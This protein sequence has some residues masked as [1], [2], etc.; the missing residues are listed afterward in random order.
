[1]KRKSIFPAAVILLVCFYC[2]GLWAAPTTGRQAETA[3][4]GW[5]Q[6]NPNPLGANLGNQ[7]THAETF[8]D[9]NNQ[10]LYHIVYL[11]PEGF[12][13]VSADDKVEPIIG[14]VRD[15]MYDP[16]D[17]NPLA[18]LLNAD[19]RGRIAAARGAQG[20]ADATEFQNKWSGLTTAGENLNE[21][22][23]GDDIA[24]TFGIATIDEPRIDPLL[25]T[26]W[27]Q[28]DVA[29]KC[30]N[31]Y[32]PNQYPCGCVATAMAQLMYYYQH[33]TGGIGVHGFSIKINTT[34]ETWYTRGGDGIGGAYD[35]S[36]MVLDPDL[37]TTDTERKAMGALCYDA[38]LSVNMQYTSSESTANTLDAADAF[39][40]TFDYENAIKGYNSGSNIGAGLNG[41]IN[42]NLDGREAVI[43][44]ITGD[45]GHAIVCD[46]YGYNSSTMYHHLNLGWKE[47]AND[48]WYNLPTIVTT[49][50]DH[51]YTSVYKCV[52]NIRTISCNND[53]V[54]SGRVLDN[55]GDPLYM[56]V[57]LTSPDDD[58]AMTDSRGIYC[59]K[60]L[61]SAT[62]YTVDVIKKGFV[63]D[64]EVIATG[65]SVNNTSTS[66]NVW[67]VDLSG[68]VFEITGV[69]PVSGPPGSY[70]KIEGVNF[71]SSIG[72]V[73][74]KG[75]QSGDIQL[76]TDTLIYC[77][78]P[79]G[80]SSGEGEVS[81]QTADNDSSYGVPFTVTNPAEV[82]V[83]PNRSTTNIENGTA[84]YPFSTIQRGVNAGTVAGRR[85]VVW[86]GVYYENVSFNGI[87]IILT[88]TDPNNAEVVAATVI[89]GD[90]NGS[91]VSFEDGEGSECVLRG[92]TIRN[93]SSSYGGGVRCFSSAPTIKQCNI[94][95]NTASCGGGICSM[96]LSPTIID[97]VITYNLAEAG[98]G[99]YFY[100]CSPVMKRCIVA[101]NEA[102]QGGGG[103]LY[104]YLLAHR[105]VIDHCLIVG[106]TS[107]I[108]GAIFTYDSS[109][110]VRHCDI[111][112]NEASQYAG[113]I[114]W[115]GGYMLIH[116]TILWNGTTPGNP[117]ELILLSPPSPSYL[118]IWSSDVRGGLMGVF[119]QS[120][121]SLHW[122]GSNVNV[123]PL[124]VRDP[125]MEG[126]DFG[127]LHL[128]A[129]SGCI[130]AGDAEFD[131]PNDYDFDKHTRII[132]GDC[133]GAKVIDIG[134]YEFGYVYFGD[135]SGDCNVDLEDFA[136]FATA[137][138]SKEGEGHFE[139]ACDIGV[140]EDGKIDLTDLE[141]FAEHWTTGRD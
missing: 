22:T 50:P 48:A 128:Q 33:P 122:H 126:D 106:N 140:P 85:V 121:S 51:T 119:D 74:V 70:I 77:R 53:E 9:E 129:E 125:N 127:D 61:K 141:V 135:F 67:G 73:T 78:V 43:L 29:G 45:G 55:N 5:L 69:T 108:G 100:T 56:A 20:P 130:D 65:T 76:W 72:Q 64:E 95:D 58:A 46:G 8:T 1:M 102:E 136:I 94:T 52:Y 87:D 49:N 24:M 16:S 139:A 19:L 75:Q 105:P 34:W 113:G 71:G 36:N 44:G 31:Y 4:A 103:Y 101:G 27:S 21:G 90:Y 117:D 107:P 2:G 99:F 7:I 116:H 14:F 35:W 138:L 93:G 124:F 109:V 3:A 98:G 91:G 134:A 88:S 25:Q 30:F 59:L 57:V 40:G 118:T 84:E 112:C 80:L 38:G 12:V 17:D 37:Y 66:G 63:F 62:T 133:D 104:G 131:D 68:E 96:D 10:P 82:I 79:V 81:V 39:T 60:R 97:C 6:G 47:T 137:W 86:P 132:D 92:F 32:T 42:P 123:E 111:V 18:V 83:D 13:I 54:I 23:R 41:M 114:F 28:G 120:G 89:D 115:Y 15:G 11:E 26:N 110:T